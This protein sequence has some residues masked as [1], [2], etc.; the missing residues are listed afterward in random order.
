MGIGPGD[1]KLRIGLFGAEAW[2]ESMRK[3]L[4]QVWGIKATD[5][6]GLSEVMGP[7]V[8][9]ECT[10][11]PG[12][13]IQEDHFLVEIINP[14]TGEIL[15]PGE[16]GELVITTLT[17]QAMP[18]IRY[19]TRDITRLDYQPCAC[20]RNTV[21]MKK[22]TGRSDDMMIISGVNVFPSQIES[23]LMEFDQIAPH[24]QIVVSKKGYMDALEV[25]VE[26]TEKAF[27]GNFRDLEVLEKKIRSRLHSVLTI[28]AKVRLMEPF[29]IERSQGK[30]KRVVDERPKIS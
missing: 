15:G 10:A 9:G 26:V 17:K 5:N 3:E 21:K 2:S 19:R 11:S 16:E 6:Y 30:A 7:G 24:Y 28:G 20:G 4:E 27:T 14:E 22:V 1:L 29:T 18:I 8:S 13:H 25:M 23:V 12:L